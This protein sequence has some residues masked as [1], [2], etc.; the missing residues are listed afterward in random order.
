MKK[1]KK[2]LEMV[3][4]T[5]STL[6]FRY[7]HLYI[8]RPWYQ[9]LLTG[10][11]TFLLLLIAYMAAVYFNLFWLFGKSPSLHTIM[12][13]QNSEAS[14]IYSCDGAL[15]GKYFNENR[16]PVE[17]EDVAPIFYKTLI[18]TEDERFYQ[19]H[20]VDIKGLF[21]AAKDMMKGNARGA[22]TITQQL[23]KNIFRM[24][25]Q[26]STGLL[27]K[28]PGVKMV[29]M[30]TKE[31][32]LAI[33]LEC[34]YDK[35]D[36]LTMYVNTVDFGSNAFGIKTAA[37]TY[38]DTT[39]ARLKAE[40]CAVLVGLLKATST[41]NPKL[42]PKRSLKRR[43]VVL[44]NLR[45]H[46][47]LSQAEYDSLSAMPIQLSF[48]VEN[49][50][51]GKA[52]YFRQELAKYLRDL[53][54][55]K[56][57]DVDLYSDGLKIYTTLDSRMQE[58]AEQAVNKQM[59][60]IQER[61]NNHWG[62]TPPWQDEQHREV[63]HFIEDIA[64]RLP[65]YAHLERK[66]EGNADSINHY[67]NLPHEVTVFDYDGPRKMTL[68]T[69]DSIRYM[70]SFMHTGF[71][72]LEPD[73]RHIKAWVGD[74]DYQSWKYDKV[75]AMRQ[76]GST[77]K[78]F[79]Y[80]EAMNQGLSPRD[81]R[82]DDYVGLQVFDKQKGK[83]VLWAPHNAN[84]Y[85]TGDSMTLRAAFAQSVNSIAVKTG[86]EVGVENIVKTAH[87][88]GIHSRLDAQPALTLGAS[89]VNLL[90]LVNAYATVAADG[91]EQEPVMVTKVVDRDGRVIYDEA[92]DGERPRQALPYRSAFL[93]QKMLQAGLTE[94]GAT[95]MSLWTYIRQFDRTTDFGG[96]TGTSN[97]HSDAWYVGI[98]PGLVGGAWV[99]GEYRCIHFRTGQLGQG[100]RTAL[101]IFG[102]FMQDV[103]SDPK[104]AK[105]QQKFKKPLEDIPSS[106][107]EFENYRPHPREIDSL[108]I[109]SINNAFLGD[110]LTF[111]HPT[112]TQDEVEQELS[113]AKN[114]EPLTLP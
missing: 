23:V 37:K 97:N 61:F 31:W 63:P 9:K 114:E 79:V 5:T 66:F 58:Y 101:P 51:D 4:R 41:Y 109:D 76:P 19:H 54:N 83:E 91:R 87:A 39:P 80:A 106:C 75:T 32:I 67:L 44:N 69:L 70:V 99:G 72:V 2:L 56:E 45:T 6:W 15:I 42:N 26:Y 103:L 16:S 29:I 34:F 64:R 81:R 10:F 30:K 62:S 14:E 27:G 104:F 8:R 12:H 11:A 52:L 50:Y 84:G 88:M 60:V 78:L 46:G 108:T 49:I 95:S 74:I 36:I 55:K 102:Y 24:R 90:E 1:I 3:T 47:H 111:S 40:E 73:T 28:I 35:K 96:K 18:D 89:D 93:M 20:G 57:M 71:V 21:A 98:T 43:N 48:S 110:S 7:K 65:V 85:F 22:S 107:Y 100:S 105:Y 59:R 13:P 94:P 86:L 25:T 113:G 33:G 17:Y 38:F 82:L 92:K 77:F 53:F 112:I 68:S